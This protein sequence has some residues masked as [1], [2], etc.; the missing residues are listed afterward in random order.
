MDFIINPWCTAYDRNS[1]SDIQ[2][3]QA[4]NFRSLVEPIKIP[5]SIKHP[6]WSRDPWTWF[7]S[8]IWHVNT[9]NWPQTPLTSFNLNDDVIV[10]VL[11][12]ERW[13]LR[14]GKVW[15]MLVFGTVT[16]YKLYN[17][18]YPAIETR[19]EQT[20]MTDYYLPMNPQAT[21]V[22]KR[23]L[24]THRSIGRWLWTSSSREPWILARW[25]QLYVF[26]YLWLKSDFWVTW[27]WCFRGEIVII[28]W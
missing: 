2:N 14:R 12:A 4:Q 11:S 15:R 5:R 6:S 7:N 17:C 1:G 9:S 24:W 19:L 25:L 27:R 26:P 8:R 20:R 18:Q 23:H 3:I 21:A 16:I 22:F 10:R 13:G 28:I